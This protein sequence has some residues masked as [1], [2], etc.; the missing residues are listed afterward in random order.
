MLILHIKYSDN[1]LAVSARIATEFVVIPFL[2]N[3]YAVPWNKELA[4]SPVEIVKRVF[5]EN[6]KQNFYGEAVAITNHVKTVASQAFWAYE[7]MGDLREGKS[8]DLRD[9]AY[10]IINMEISFSELVNF[11]EE[12]FLKLAEKENRCWNSEDI[13]IDLESFEI[14]QL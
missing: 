11:S 14:I 9:L 5:T 4:E 12:D 1:D 8:S 13:F 10:I 2:Q 6:G 3:K 7:L